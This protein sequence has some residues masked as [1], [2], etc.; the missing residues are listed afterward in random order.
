MF[1]QIEALRWI[2]KNIRAFG[3]DPA[4]VTVFG[5]SAGANAIVHMMA[6]KQTEGLFH[7]VILQSPS[8]GRGNHTAIDATRI[9]E[10]HFKH[11]GIDSNDPNLAAKSVRSPFTRF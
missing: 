8:L 4:N 10:C 5:Q 1:Y 7:K 6:L 11:L 3:G 2:Q 9:A